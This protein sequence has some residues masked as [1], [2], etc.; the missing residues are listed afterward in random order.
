LSA[1]EDGSLFGIAERAQAAGSGPWDLTR[2]E[3]AVMEIVGRWVPASV[4]RAIR[5]RRRA[6]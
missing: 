2:E 4:R 1:Y 5:Q 3:V 6:A